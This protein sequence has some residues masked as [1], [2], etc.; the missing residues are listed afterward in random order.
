MQKT[1]YISLMQE[2]T[3]SQTEMILKTI[4]IL[5]QNNLNDFELGW[6]HNTNKF[7]VKCQCILYAL[8]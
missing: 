1:I 6:R 7:R 5:N 8:Q 3:E 2:P 4:Q